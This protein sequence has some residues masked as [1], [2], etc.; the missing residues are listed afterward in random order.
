MKSLINRLLGKTSLPYEEAKRLASHQDMAV[1]QELASRE[2]VMPEILYFLA[3]D[4]SPEVRRE[5]ANNKSSP[6]HA[7]LLLVGDSDQNVRS[8]LAEKIALLAPGL[9]P[10]EQDKLQRMTYEALEALA[11]DQVVRVRQIL[12]E[13]LKDFTDVSPEV[14]RRLARDAEIVVSGPV[15]EYSPVLTDEDLLEIIREDTVTGK[16]N[17]IATRANLQEPVSDAIVD[18]DDKEAITLLLAN[19]SAQIREETLDFLVD[20]AP[21]VELWHEPLVR[22]PGLPAKAATRLAMFVADNLIEYLSERQ[23]LDQATIA[24]VRQEVARR[25]EENGGDGGDES[26]TDKLLKKLQQ[27]H[28]SDELDEKTIAEALEAGKHP[29]VMAALSVRSGL[30]LNIVEKITSTQSSKGT[31]AMVWKA[32]LSMDFGVTVQQ[33]LVHIP[34]KDIMHSRGGDFPMADEEMEWQLEFFSDMS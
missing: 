19:E 29:W 27:L 31:V 7:D 30:P 6:P 9:S 8:S 10:D 23:D 17:A 4:P 21:D 14:I 25:L 24:T 15:L 28:S 33:R 22:R 3:E 5:I 20:K 34:F 2:D 11:R 26:D 1:R 13:T 16:L 18:T 32:G 12:S